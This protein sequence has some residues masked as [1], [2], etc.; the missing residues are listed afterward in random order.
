MGV[1]SKFNKSIKAEIEAG[2]IDANIQGP[3]IEAAKKVAR[4]MDQK[5]WPMVNGKVDNVSPSVFLKYCE[6]LG[7]TPDKIAKPADK[8]TTMRVLG[9]SKWK[10]R[11]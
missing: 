3:I 9:E 10:K 4:V 2:R 5:G 11:A 8:N 1:L 6:K 7:L